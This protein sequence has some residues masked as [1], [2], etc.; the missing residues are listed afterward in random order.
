MHD[1]YFWVL[2]IS[3]SAALIQFKLLHL[4]IPIAEGS[5]GPQWIRSSRSY[6]VVFFSRNIKLLS[7]L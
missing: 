2:I 7:I 1:A 5:G 4:R 6:P 3:N